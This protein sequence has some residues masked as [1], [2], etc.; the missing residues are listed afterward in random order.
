LPPLVRAAI[1]CDALSSLTV[2]PRYSRRDQA[3]SA[4]MRF[5]SPQKF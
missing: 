3:T 2:K 1:N 4:Q 5:A